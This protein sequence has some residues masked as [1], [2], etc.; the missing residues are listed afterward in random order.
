[1]T[2]EPVQAPALVREVDDQRQVSAGNLDLPFPSTLGRSGG[3]V[4]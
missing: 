2:I 1:M 4:R 3:A